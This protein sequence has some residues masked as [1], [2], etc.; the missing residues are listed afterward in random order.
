MLSYMKQKRYFILIINLLI[1]TF[2]FGQT[3]E[4]VVRFAD[5][6]FGKGNF[7]VAAQEYNRAFFFGYNKVDEVSMQIGHCYSELSNYNL[8][9]TFYDRAFKYSNSDSLKNEAVLGK[10]FCLIMQNKNLLALNELLYLSNQLNMQQQTGVHYLKGIAYYGL[11]EDTLAFEEFYSVLDN[12]GANDTLKTLLSSEFLKVYRY[13]KR[14][15]PNRAYIISGLLPGSGQF[16]V[17]AFKEGIN[18]MLLIAVLYFISIEIIR[19]YS[20]IDAAIA[21][22]PWIQRYYMGGMD[23]AKGLAISKIEAKRYESYLHIIKLTTPET[24]R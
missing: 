20:F 9:A 23:K 13:H 16:S 8:A 22:F 10:T 21:M 19:D 15:N 7:Q 24:F 11:G 18:S 4:D 14:F 2:S 1:V 6:Q 3:V 17:G 12:A 5:E